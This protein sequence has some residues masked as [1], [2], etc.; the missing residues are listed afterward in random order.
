M[1]LM[2]AKNDRIALNELFERTN[3][4]A[5]DISD[6]AAMSIIKECWGKMYGSMNQWTKAYNNFFDAFRS[7]QQIGDANVKQCLKYVV[8]ASMLAEEV[9]NPFATQEAGV[10][11][12]DVEI[13]P[14]GKL[15]SAFEEDDIVGFESVLNKDKSRILNDDFIAEN[16]ASVQLRLRSRV[17]VKLIKPYRRVKLKWLCRQLNAKM[18]EVENL[19]VNLILDGS[20]NG[21]LDQMN[22]L[23]DL[24][25]MFRSLFFFSFFL[26]FLSFLLRIG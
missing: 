12:N 21:R 23:L 4:L 6:P 17:L 7:Y 16:M 15:L 22:S 24:T 18:E 9:A 5:S 11:Q 25:F 8:I 13:M 3:G 20:I 19:V 10:Y 1:Q 26:S 14:I 2:A